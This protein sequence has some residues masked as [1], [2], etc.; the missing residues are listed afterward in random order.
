MHALLVHALVPSAAFAPTPLTRHAQ[1]RLRTQPPALVAPSGVD[2]LPYALQQATVLAG[3]AGLGAATL[4]SASA[5]EAVRRASDESVWWQR[6]ETFAAATLGVT[7]VLAGRSHFTMPEAFKAIYPPPGTWGFWYLPGSSDFHVAWTGVAELLGGAGLLIGCLLSVVGQVSMGRELRVWV[8]R[9]VFL[10]VLAVSPANM[11][12]FTHGAVMPG[13]TP[14]ELPLGWHAGRFV[15]QALVLSVLLTTAQWGLASQRQA[16]RVDGQAQPEP[17]P[18]SAASPGGVSRGGGP[19][20]Q[21]SDEEVEA[22]LAKMRG[23][24]GRGGQ[25]EGGNDPGVVLGVEA[26]EVGVVLV[27]LLALALFCLEEYVRARL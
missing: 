15:A 16:K 20:M 7:F 24:S 25:P 27:P 11:Y 23:S 18:E 13:V 14:D 5:Y 19:R 8:A 10:L 26:L 22:K 2:E 17:E 9:A 6:W 1:P 21:L 3:F 4:A 12:M